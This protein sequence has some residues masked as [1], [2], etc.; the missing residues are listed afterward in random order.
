MRFADEP[1]LPGV[2]LGHRAAGVH[3]RGDRVIQRVVG[4]GPVAVL[5]RLGLG[6]HDPEHARMAG[7]HVGQAGWFEDVAKARLDPA[8]RG[9]DRFDRFGVAEDLEGLDGRGCR[10]PVAGVRPAVADLARQDAHHL[11]GATERGRRVAVTHRLGVRREVGLDRSG[12]IV[13]GRLREGEKIGI[14]LGADRMHPEILG[15]GI[16]AAVAIK[17]GHRLGAALGERFA[18]DVAGI[19]HCQFLQSGSGWAAVGALGEPRLDRVPDLRCDRNAVER[20]ISWMPVGEVTLIS[21]SQSPI[22][23]M[24]TNTSP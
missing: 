3:P 7:E 19:G 14:D 16:A 6:E 9:V 2:G 21:V 23:S 1:W 5:G 11:G 22:T 10:D 24:P 18:E 17:A 20:A 15:P 4:V 13:A 8:T 12:Q